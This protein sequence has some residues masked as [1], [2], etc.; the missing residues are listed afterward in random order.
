MRSPPTSTTIRGLERR[1]W[2]RVTAPAPSTSSWP[3]RFA[4][5][6][7]GNAGEGNIGMSRHAL[8]LSHGGDGSNGG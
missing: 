1:N 8:S 7:S 3:E 5:R 4:N 2:S 6:I